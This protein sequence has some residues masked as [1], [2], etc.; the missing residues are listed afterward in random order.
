MSQENVEV[1][2]WSRTAW[3][4]FGLALIGGELRLTNRRLV[5]LPSRFSSPR[6]RGG[7]EARL[8]EITSVGIEP[9][10]L[11]DGLFGLRKR[12]RIHTK[13]GGTMV[14][15]VN[16]VSQLIEELAAAGLPVA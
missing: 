15:G 9:R 14:I 4:D 5:F 12:L 11:R 16:G 10:R 13:D 7:W 2:R 3:V 1:V 6:R 8:D